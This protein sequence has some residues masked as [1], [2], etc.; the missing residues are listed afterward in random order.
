MGMKNVEKYTRQYF[1]PPVDCMDWAK[2]DH[3]WLQRNRGWFPGSFRDRVPVLKN[4][5]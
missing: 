2:K 4:P 5:D 1:M 3:N